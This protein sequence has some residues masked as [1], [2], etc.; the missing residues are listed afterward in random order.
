MRCFG[1]ESG[2]CCCACCDVDMGGRTNRGGG[3]N[4]WVVAAWEGVEGIAKGQEA[5]DE[6]GGGEEDVFETDPD[7]V[8]REDPAI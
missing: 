5:V 3:G 8:I 1:A 2:M 6:V 4:V 7:T